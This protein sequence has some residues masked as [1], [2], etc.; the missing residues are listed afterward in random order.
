MT[1][2]LPAAILVMACL[3]EDGRPHWLELVLSNVCVV[4]FN[5]DFNLIPLPEVHFDRYIRYRA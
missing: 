5:R 1:Y 3:L 2:L 4:L